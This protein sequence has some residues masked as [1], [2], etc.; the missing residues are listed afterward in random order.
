MSMSRS[1]L[2]RSQTLKAGEQPVWGVAELYIVEGTRMAGLVE[3]TPPVPP[4]NEG[5]SYVKANGLGRGEGGFVW[6]Y[7]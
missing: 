6:T 5:S 1:C 4:Y 3:N 7:D 2:I